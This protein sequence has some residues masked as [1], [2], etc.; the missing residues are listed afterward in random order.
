MVNIMKKIFAAFVCAI[1]S[2]VS[3]QAQIAYGPDTKFDDLVPGDKAQRDKMFWQIQ[4]TESDGESETLRIFYRDAS[5][6][7]AAGNEAEAMD[8]YRKMHALWWD[9]FSAAP[10]AIVSGCYP[11]LY[12]NPCYM[13]D[14]LIEHETDESMRMRYFADMMTMFKT[15]LA[16]LDKLNALQQQESNKTTDGV[17]KCIM[18]AYYFRDGGFILA[19]NPD[20]RTKFYA[21]TYDMFKEG[22]N[23]I[24]RDGGRSVGSFALNSYMGL[25]HYRYQNEGDSFKENFLNDYQDCRA[26]CDSMLNEARDPNYMG[27]PVAIINQYDPILRMCDSLFYTSGAADSASVVAMLEPK[28]EAN[29]NDLDYLNKAL[30]LLLDNELDNSE[31]YYRASEYAYAINPTYESAI[32]MAKRKMDGGDLNAALGLYRDAIS[33]A[34]NDTQKANIAMNVAKSLKSAKRYNEAMG[35]LEDAGRYNPTIKGKTLYRQAM[36]QIDTEQYSRA[37]DLLAKAK[38]ADET[39]AGEVDRKLEIITRVEEQIAE[40]KK[41]KR[42]YDAA[43]AAKQ[44]EEDFW[45]KGKQG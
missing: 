6:A 44:A 45:T 41:Q 18:A 29:K 26:V 14:Y 32:G 23:Q 13:F 39:L 11:Y 17:V 28:I 7:V 22:I 36:I 2:S 34:Y 1:L 43:R 8:S 10:L 4:A 12:I 3:M 25:S 21:K 27:D 37:R 38:L 30:T 16:N 19:N 20:K 9:I 31:I 33:M 35:Y 24:K 15:R 42:A 5:R 40:Y